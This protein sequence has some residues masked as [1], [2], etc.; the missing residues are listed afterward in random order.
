MY[1]VYP[2]ASSRRA[3]SR[4]HILSYPPLLW[5][6]ALYCGNPVL[7]ESI[8][9]VLLFPEQRVCERI[10]GYLNIRHGACYNRR[11]LHHPHFLAKRS[12]H[13]L[14]RSPPVPRYQGAAPG[15]PTGLSGR[16]FLRVLR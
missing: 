6:W 3:I 7:T 10:V 4:T 5:I 12:C 16:G 9:P 8:R 15:C 1:H 14:T 13:G 11:V 2:I